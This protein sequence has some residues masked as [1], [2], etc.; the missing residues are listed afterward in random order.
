MPKNAAKRIEKLVA[1]L[2]EHNYRYH[3]LAD[4]AISDQ[5]YDRLLA[6]LQQL[7][8]AHPDLSPPDSPA[9]RVG[10]ETT[11]EFPTVRHAAPMLSLDNSYSRQDLQAFDKR[12]R[13]ALPGEEIKYVA[14]LKIDGVALSLV[15]EDSLLVQAATRGDGVQG[16]EITAN[17]RTIR[18]IPLRLR[19]AGI[20]CEVRGEVYMRHDSFAALNDQRQEREESDKN[21]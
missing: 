14:E 17:A 19:R 11:S 5:D 1:E 7:E 18:S 4:P 2:N 3:V 16:D 21:Q 9:Q 13:D 10:G 12:V 8:E 20:T 15:Y 6:E